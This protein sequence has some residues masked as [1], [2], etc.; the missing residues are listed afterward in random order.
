MGRQEEIEKVEKYICKLF[1][2]RAI[3]ANLVDHNIGS[4]G[5]FEIAYEPNEN[6]CEGEAFYIKAKDYTKKEGGK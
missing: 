5:R 6:G 2:P 1:S 3:A 4:A